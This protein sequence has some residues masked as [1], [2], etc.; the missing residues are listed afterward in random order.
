MSAVADYILEVVV[1]S[2]GIAV[3]GTESIAVR[4]SRLSLD[5]SVVTNVVC[6][7]TV[8]TVVLL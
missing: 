6:C 1:D 7:K 5:S 2:V 4:C 8:V 3:L